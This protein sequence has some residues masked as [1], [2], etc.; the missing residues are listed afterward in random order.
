MPKYSH[1]KRPSFPDKK[2]KCDRRKKCQ[3]VRGADVLTFTRKNQNCFFFE[4]YIV[5]ITLFSP[6]PVYINLK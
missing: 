2:T 4:N 5:T 1:Y 3:N 6:P